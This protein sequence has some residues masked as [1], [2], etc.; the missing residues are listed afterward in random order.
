M[1]SFKLIFFYWD[2]IVSYWQI[3]RDEADVF[4]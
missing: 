1:H 4:S 2:F 3:L